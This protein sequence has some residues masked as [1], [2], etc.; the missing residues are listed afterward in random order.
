MASNDSEVANRMSGR[1]A[2]SALRRPAGVS[3]CQRPTVRPSHAA[4][5]PQPV[6]EGSGPVPE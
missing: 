6:A 3:P 2:D 4:Q 1:S 5:R